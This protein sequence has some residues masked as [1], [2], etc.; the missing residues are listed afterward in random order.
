MSDIWTEDDHIVELDIHNKENLS[1]DRIHNVIGEEL[2]LFKK[3]HTININ[4]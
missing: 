2:Q 4:L 3:R 1:A